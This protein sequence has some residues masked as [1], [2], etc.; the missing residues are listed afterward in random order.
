MSDEKLDKRFCSKYFHDIEH[1]FGTGDIIL[2]RGTEAFSLIIR[3]GTMSTWSHAAMIVKDPSPQVRQAF[4]IDSEPF[5]QEKVFIFESDTVT[6]DGR[7]GGGT[8]MV[9]FR[10]W[11]ES[12][13][14]EY[15]ESYLVVYR[16]LQCP[17]EFQ[18]KLYSEVFPE[19]DPWLISMANLG[20]ESSRSQLVRSAI[21]VNKSEDL[22]SV[23]CSELV[24]AALKHLGIL[25]KDRNANNYV[26][27]DFTSDQRLSG[28]DFTVH[29]PG[30]S[31]DKEIRVRYRKK[32]DGSES[33]AIETLTEQAPAPALGSLAT[34]SVGSIS[35][36]SINIES[37]PVGLKSLS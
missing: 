31:Y 11:L 29:R 6:H 1:N 33:V 30:F 26:P 12:S 16:H 37:H 27:R 22:T 14:E 25:R 2:S 20:Y 36:S 23:F 15:G 8:Q 24:A 18:D 5:L 17:Q 10:K 19:L 32:L 35:M 21:H 7:Q 3:K 13:I 34:Q 28:R 9:P 4:K